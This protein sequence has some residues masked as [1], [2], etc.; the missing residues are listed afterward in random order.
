[1]VSIL[2]SSC[3][4]VLTTLKCIYSLSDNLYATSI[5]GYFPSQCGCN[6]PSYKKCKRLLVNLLDEHVIKKKPEN[7]F[8][9]T[10]N[11]D[12][13]YCWSLHWLHCFL[14]Q[15]HCLHK[16]PKCQVNHFLMILDLTCYTSFSVT[17]PALDIN[18]QLDVTPKI[19]LKC[20]F[21]YC[22]KELLKMRQ[23]YM[24]SL[25]DSAD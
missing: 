1:M 6:R 16:N 17:H 8:L 7:C 3:S 20:R 5:F 18:T 19:T 24:T 13:S 21:L 23:Q 12:G 14:N 2:S 25:S 22:T 10:Q 15:K 11:F 4:T 9:V